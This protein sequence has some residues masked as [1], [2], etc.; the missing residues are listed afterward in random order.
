[1]GISLF[2][3][4]SFGEGEVMRIPGTIWIWGKNRGLAKALLSLVLLLGG[5]GCA[6]KSQL[7]DYPVA[8]GVNFQ[9]PPSN[10]AVV[11]FLRP[12]RAASA[13]SAALYEGEKFLC[14]LMSRTCFIYETTP[15]EH[16]FMVVS[17]AADFFET[18]LAGGRIYFI[19]A[20]PR[21]GWWRARFSLRAITPSSADW[22]NL[23]RWVA[24]CYSVTPNQLGQNWSRAHAWDVREKREAYLAKWLQKPNRPVLRPVDGV[25]SFP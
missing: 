5:L 3:V 23:P 12:S 25:E 21:M 17:E 18:N 4:R 24:A 9:P 20:V 14:I 19:E 6:T 8:P 2:F 22:P 11:C 13:N 1:M 10:K 15:G 7:V 16:Q